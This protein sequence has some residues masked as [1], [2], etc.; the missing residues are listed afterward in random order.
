M[1]VPFPKMSITGDIGSGKSAVSRI[2]QRETDFPIYSTGD[3]QRQIATRYGM[4]TL[5]LNKYSES[6]PEIDDEID[7]ES[8]R[9]GKTDESFILDSRIA[10]HFIPHSF[11]IYLA[12]DLDVAAGRILGD[13]ERTG[14]SYDDLETAKSDIRQRRRSEVERFKRIYDIDLSN[15]S[16]YDLIVDTSKEMP[17]AIA[18]A[19]LEAFQEW[20]VKPR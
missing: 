5:E 12:V 8:I 13:R 20:A 14:E 2:L 3:L 19:V 7:A 17:E 1:P 4:T 15:M 6:H 18:N 16:N 10:W 9:L 11:K